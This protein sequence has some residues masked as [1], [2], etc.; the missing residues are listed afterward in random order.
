MLILF[1]NLFIPG[2]A[3]LLCII[4][5]FYFVMIEQLEPVN[6][7]RFALFLLSFG[8][9]LISRPLQI[10]LGPYPLP[11]IINN[12]RLLLFC[13]VTVP[14][15]LML[16]DEAGKPETGYRLKLTIGIG[17]LL[18]A[19]YGVFNILGTQGSYEIFRF[20]NIV[21][22]D[23]LSPSMRKPYYGREVTIAV[24]VLMGFVLS[25]SAGYR[26]FKTY[27]AKYKDQSKKSFYYN[28]GILI[29]GLSLILG[30]IIK[31]WWIYYS[32]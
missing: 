27:R 5:F 21:A 17:F 14:M 16:T 11:L 26:I 18:G 22:Y 25:G 6:A 32:F 7:K 10:L 28:A 13:T 12:L 31:K 23:N 2:I 8:I 15:V 20:G 4:F 9:F 1:G 24:S 30:V 19:V 3:S 29:F